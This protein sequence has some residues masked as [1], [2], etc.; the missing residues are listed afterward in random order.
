MADLWTQKSAR[1]RG[2]AALMPTI[3]DFPTIVKDAVDIFGDLCAN[4]P[5][6]RYFAEYL[7]GLMVVCNPS[8]LTSGARRAF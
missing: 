1:L 4:E 3:V 8:R 5:E 7:T 6:R 2:E